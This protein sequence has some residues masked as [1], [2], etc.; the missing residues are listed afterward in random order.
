MLP[1]AIPAFTTRPATK[2]PKP[3]YER[4]VMPVITLP[5][6]EPLRGSLQ[7]IADEHNRWVDDGGLRTGDLGPLDVLLLQLRECEVIASALKR[8]CEE[9]PE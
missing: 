6:D 9:E 5:T 4:I 3:K 8:E 1:I 7:K 2:S